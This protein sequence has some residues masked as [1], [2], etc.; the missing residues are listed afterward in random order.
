MAAMSERHSYPRNFLTLS[1]PLVLFKPAVVWWIP[2]KKRGATSEL[3]Y[4]LSG[5]NP[6]VGEIEIGLLTSV[7]ELKHRLFLITVC[8]GCES[9]L[10]V[11]VLGDQCFCKW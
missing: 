1:S 2:G 10:E 3:A 5:E 7:L 4:R 11:D 6:G 9:L 8:D